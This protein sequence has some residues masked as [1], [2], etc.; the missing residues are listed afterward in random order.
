MTLLY[1]RNYSSFGNLARSFR[2]KEN[3]LKDIVQ[4]MLSTIR[5]PLFSALVRPL[6]KAAQVLEGNYA[7]NV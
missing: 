6:G 2:L 5:D 1:L 3:T 7:F 4:R